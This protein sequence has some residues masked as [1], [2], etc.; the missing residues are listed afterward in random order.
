MTIG[1]RCLS[2]LAFGVFLPINCAKA[3]Q[4]VLSLPLLCIAQE[5]CF[6]QNYVD[7]DPSPSVRDWGCGKSSYDGHKGVDFRIVS[8]A[9]LKTGVRVIAAAPGVIKG[10][11]S[12]MPDRLM[13]GRGAPD[14]TGREC[15]NGL[16]IDHGEGWETQYCHLRK[17]S[18]LVKKGDRVTRGQELGLVGLSGKTTFPHVHLSV[19]HNKKTIDPFHGQ[20]RSKTTCRPKSK[21]GPLWQKSV[22]MQFPYASGQ[23]FMW[24]FSH[25]S[26][27]KEILMARGAMRVPQSTKAPGL[28]FY[29]QALNLQKGD[30]L[31]IKLTGPKGFVATTHKRM[32]KN[33]A[34]YLLFAGK[35]RPGALWPAGTY[36]GA[37]ILRRDGK[38]VWEQSRELEWR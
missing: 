7:L 29:G 38:Q 37:F 19:R 13:G 36:K 9:A 26:V 32:V 30:Q 1:R 14:I 3:Q 20:Q 6:I 11:R 34:T 24:G 16:V 5:T 27:G 17:N 22:Q 31:L 33:M 23:P 4:P 21:Y 25:R 18:L 2:L 35:K 8:I 12:D 28:V 10:M 15:G